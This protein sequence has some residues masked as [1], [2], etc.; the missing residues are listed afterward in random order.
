ML[1]NVDI[2]SFADYGHRKIN[3]DMLK[4]QPDES[5]KQIASWYVPYSYLCFQD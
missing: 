3:T 4:Q 1:E 5:S 2:F